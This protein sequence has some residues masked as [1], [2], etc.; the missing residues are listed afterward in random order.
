MCV[1]GGLK[2]WYCNAEEGSGDYGSNDYSEF[3]S[4]EIIN[5]DSR[6]GEGYFCD[7]GRCTLPYNECRVMRNRNP[8]VTWT[9]WCSCNVSST[10]FTCSSCEFG[11]NN[12]TG[13]C[14]EPDLIVTREIINLGNDSF[15]VE[16]T[17]DVNENSNITSFIIT[18]DYPIGWQVVNVSHGGVWEN[19]RRLNE[20]IIEWIG[21]DDFSEL[22]IE[23]TT[24]IYNIIKTN[25]NSD[26]S[27][28]WMTVDN[29]GDIIG[30][31]NA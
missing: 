20:S 11:C 12:I 4:Y 14:I 22:L 2:E 29:Q 23:D 10:G 18:E 27:G 28:S 24:I 31:E 1:S 3:C 19:S 13:L 17:I 15:R 5:C 9:V 7:A 25:S 26:F 6:M 21:N 8:N 16:L 30:D